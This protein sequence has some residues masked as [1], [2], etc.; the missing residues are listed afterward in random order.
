ME[1]LDPAG[2]G[3]GALLPSGS[4]YDQLRV[5]RDSVRMSLVDATNPTVFV[6]DAAF[7]LFAQKDVAEY[8]RRE[9]ATLMGLDPMVDAQPKVAF[10]RQAEGDDADIEIRAYSMGVLH[11]AVPM[12]VALGLG[13]AA[14]VQGTIAYGMMS[15]HNLD[16]IVRIKHPGGIVHVGA[17][18]EAD[19]KVQSAKVLMTGRRLM[20]GSVYW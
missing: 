5:G 1:F 14:N 10:I 11:K 7:E 2:A 4:S 12:T 18:V 17:N 20:E 16:G 8:F 13:V 19:G 6:E 9:G 3:T 15:T